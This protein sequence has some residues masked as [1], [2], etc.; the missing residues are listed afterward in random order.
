M[1]QWQLSDP[2]KQV[3]DAGTKHSRSRAIDAR[4]MPRPLGDTSVIGLTDSAC[5]CPLL[6]SRVLSHGQGAPSM[7]LPMDRLH[8]TVEMD[9]DSLHGCT[10]LLHVGTGQRVRQ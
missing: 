1:S 10:N 7:Q 3:V 4:L 5:A 2:R 8:S 6:S 9:S